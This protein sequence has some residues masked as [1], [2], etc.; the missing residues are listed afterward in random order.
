MISVTTAYFTSG[1]AMAAHLTEVAEKIAELGDI[2]KVYLGLD[3]QITDHSGDDIADPARMATVDAISSALGLVA[4]DEAWSDGTLVRRAGRHGVAIYGVRPKPVEV[5]REELLA[6]LAQLDAQIATVRPTQADGDLDHGINLG[7]TG[8]LSADD[9]CSPRWGNDKTEWEIGDE[10]CALAQWGNETPA[11]A[12]TRHNKWLASVL[13]RPT[14]DLGPVV[15]PAVDSPTIG[16]DRIEEI[17]A[18]LFVTRPSRVEAYVRSLPEF[19]AVIDGCSEG[20]PVEVLLSADPRAAAG[21]RIFR[22]LGTNVW[23]VR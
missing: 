15:P 4:A 21:T 16:P 23:S 5:Q 1:R 19:V 6:Q 13:D 22:D 10:T 2:S 11:D 20:W 7:P 18:E 12:V 17:L 3:F 9:H 14:S 8:P